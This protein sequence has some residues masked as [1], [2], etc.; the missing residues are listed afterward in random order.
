MG[1]VVRIV[2]IVLGLLVA[3]SAAAYFVVPPVASRTETLTIERPAETVFA[4]LSSTPAGATIA[5]GVTLAE[6]TSAAD[7][8]VTG[9]VNYADGATGRVTYTVTPQ[10]E[11][12]QVQMKL[13]QDLGP[14]PLDR[15]QALTGGEVGPIV[16]A[17]AAS[18]STDLN[19]LPN[20]TFTGL[21]Y[22]IE[23]VAGK[24]FFYVENC[25]G[26]DTESITSIVTQ[27]VGAIPP[28]MRA[29]GLTTDGPLMAVEP[30]VVQG[31]YCYQIG[32]PYRGRQPRALLIGKVGQT[33]AGTVLRMP[34]TGTEADVMAQVY[35][36]M[37][38]LLAAAHLDNPA[39]TDDDWVTYEVYNDDPTQEGGS[40]DR[41]I[42]YVA[43]GD[44]SALTRI[45]P[46]TAA[47]APAA[48]PAEAPAPAAPA[49]TETPAAPAPA[50]PAPTP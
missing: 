11:G 37:D 35:N 48:A 1:G 27:A 10:G 13:E 7:N 19:A 9:A 8:V 22:T 18:L 36:R 31:Q 30:R 16:E 49:A 47:A 50:A 12:T 33:P 15:V 34:Y 14:N 23:E 6:I 32:Y 46:P 41:V 17:A 24:P 3:G 38:A 4:R 29:N 21:A 44:L 2:L 42:Y 5:E 28:V 39:T 43:Q 26:S 45:A 20:A 25:S 40:R